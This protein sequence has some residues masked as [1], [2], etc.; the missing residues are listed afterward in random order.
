MSVEEQNEGHIIDRENLPTDYPTH[1]HSAQ[2]WEELGRTVAT[3]GFLEEM[4]GKAIFA[5]TGMK[6]FDPEADPDAFAEWIKTLEKALT[7]QLGGLI[8]AYEKALAENDKTKGHDFTALL[9]ALKEAKNIRNVICHGSWQKPDDEGR[10]LP[11]F[12]NRKLVIFETLV[13]TEFLRTTR[14]A[15][16]DIICDV[17]DSVTSLGFQFPGSDGPGQVLWPKQMTLPDK[18]V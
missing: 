13:D 6:E 17:F 15:V 16:V 9:E 4:L 2:F 7:D 11:K 5:L 12:V 3:F 14:R 8:F 18:D 1:A 10:T